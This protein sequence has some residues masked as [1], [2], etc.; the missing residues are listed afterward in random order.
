M[1]VGQDKG[2]YD[3]L[4]EIKQSWEKINKTSTKKRKIN[5]PPAAHDVYV[6]ASVFFSSLTGLT[7]ALCQPGAPVHSQ[8][9]FVR[10]D[11]LH[12]DGRIHSSVLLF[13]SYN[14]GRVSFPGPVSQ[15]PAFTSR[16]IYTFSRTFA[17]W[18]E[19][20]VGVRGWQLSVVRVR[21]LCWPLISSQSVSCFLT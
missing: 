2:S 19:Q 4:L 20:G 5:F 14:G 13:W 18:Q 8:P 6:K 9:I 7:V 1:T 21:M 3:P 17:V 10:Q 12:R 16:L 11:W 15:Q